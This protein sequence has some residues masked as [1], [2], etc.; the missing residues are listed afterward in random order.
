MACLHRDH[1]DGAT[2]RPDPASN[3]SIGIG[4]HGG[5]PATPDTFPFHGLI[6]ELRQMRH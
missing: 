3:P 5:Y 1:D 2:R 4:N 6:D